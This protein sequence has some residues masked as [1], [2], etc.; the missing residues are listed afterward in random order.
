VEG[1]TSRSQKELNA[2]AQRREEAKRRH[3]QVDLL[4]D[5]LE[6][7]RKRYNVNHLGSDPVEF[8]HR[9]DLPADQEVVGLIASSLAYGNV[10]TIRGSVERVLDRLGPRPSQTVK[11]LEPRQSLELFRRFKHRWT[12]GRD[13]A[14]LVYFAR[15]MMEQAGTIGGFFEAT[16]D[17]NQDMAFA[18]ERFTD[19]ALA[20]DHG[21]IYRGKKLPRKAGVRYF[22]P[23]P[24]GGGACKRLNLYLRWMVRPKDEVDLGQW[25]FVPTSSLVIPLDTHISRIGQHL[26]WTSRKTPG[27]KMAMDITRTLALVD[28]EDPTKFDF[29]L[30]RMGILENCPRHPKRSDC[31]LCKLRRQT[32]VAPT[33][34]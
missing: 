14:C 19:L 31:D 32:K 5:G 1:V 2:K 13:V 9:Y 18:L 33:S 8:L 17:P 16:F 30:S 7:L 34:A 15:Q 28:P 6:A 21:G 11:E 12:T 20:L 3:K 25:N 24:A 29:A 26:G 23:S 22:F 27:W 10:T 4:R